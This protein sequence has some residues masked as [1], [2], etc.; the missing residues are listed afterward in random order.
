[1]IVGD[2]EDGG[3]DA[4]AGA[5]ADQRGI[6]TGAQR[7]RQRIEQDRFAGAGLAGQHR[8][9]RRQLDAQLVDDDDVAD[10]QGGEHRAAGAV[11]PCLPPNALLIHDPLFS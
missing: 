10:G 8:H 11:R 6:A 9:R 3:D 2:G 7:Q 5:L 1:M 4:L